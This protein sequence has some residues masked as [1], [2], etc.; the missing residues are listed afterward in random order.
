MPLAKGYSKRVIQKN[1]RKMMH[2]NPGRD[3]AQAAAIAY[4]SARK[5]APARKMAGLMPMMAPGKRP[6]MK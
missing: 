2:E 3:P 6:G 5:H 1:I 4:S